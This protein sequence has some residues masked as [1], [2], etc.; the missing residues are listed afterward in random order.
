MQ[1]EGNEAVLDAYVAGVFAGTCQAVATK[2]HLLQLPGYELCLNSTLVDYVLQQPFVLPRVIE[3]FEQ[4]RKVSARGFNDFHYPVDRWLEATIATPYFHN[5]GDQWHPDYHL[6]ADANPASLPPD[7]IHFM[8]YVALCHLKYGPSYAS[9]T[10]NR[11]FDFA[12]A[13]GSDEVARLKQFGSGKLPPELTA[14]TD[15]NVHCTANDAF[16]TIR[17]KLSTEGADG[18]RAV[19]KFING[20]LQNEE[21]PRSYAIEFSGRA[22]HWLPVKGLPKK[23]VHALFANAARYP[24]LHPL[25]VKYAQ[26]AMRPHEWYS[27]LDGEQCALPGTF[28]VF[29][30]G[31][32]SEVYF[33]LVQQYMRAVDEEHQEIQ[34][35]F[36]VAFVERFGITD[37][38]FPVFIA[39]LLSTQ[40]HKHYKV[41]AEH[42]STRPNLE[43]L[44]ACRRDFARYYYE[45]QPAYEATADDDNSEEE[46][47]F[48][49]VW[50]D[51]LHAIF[52]PT[53]N[54]PKLVRAAP[55]ELRPLYTEL[56]TPQP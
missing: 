30:L 8:L 23:G 12:T 33:D 32:Q 52:G 48:E 18:Y 35:G 50:A 1:I 17:I 2:R 21:F 28:A 20:L 43:R 24:E 40:S 54:Y 53:K 29:A 55:E 7:Y 45:E 6:R 42:F 16:A 9:V 15:A 47:L 27:N 25:L 3:F 22:K 14:Y 11:Y 56:L 34:T 49:Y 26:L 13:L 39:C 41:V 46:G 31:L 51:V 10:A 19:L 4:L 37:Q 44:L 38:S 5:A 36:T